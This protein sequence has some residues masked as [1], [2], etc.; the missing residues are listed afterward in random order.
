MR[1][2]SASIRDTAGPSLLESTAR[3]F[4]ASVVSHLP[5][6]KTL[7]LKFFIPNSPSWSAI[8]PAQ[9]EVLKFYPS[10]LKKRTEKIPSLSA[11]CT[12]FPQATIN[13]QQQNAL[14]LKD[15]TNISPQHKGRPA[16]SFACSQLCSIAPSLSPRPEFTSTWRTWMRPRIRTLTWRMLPMIRRFC[17]AWI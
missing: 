6:N 5:A 17:G 2:F 11:P 14:L 8:R 1:F 12:T 15:P 16:S 9:D 13:P 7:T 3:L 10:K 4:T